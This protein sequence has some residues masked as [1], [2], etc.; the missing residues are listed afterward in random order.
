MTGQQRSIMPKSLTQ[1]RHVFLDMDG[2]IYNGTKLFPTTPGFLA[3]L[4]A[5]GRG[6]TFLTNNSSRST[7]E[8]VAKLA[9]MGLPSEPE[10][11]Y[12]STDYAIDYLKTNHPEFSRLYLLGVPAI[13]PAF[14]AAGFQLVEEAPDA[15]IVAFDKTLTY[16]TLCRAAWFIREG[17][18]AF[19]THPDVFCPAEPG[20]WLVDCG[21][22]TACLESSTGK[23]ITVLGKPDP[24]FLRAAAARKGVPVEDVLMCGDRVSTDIALGFYAGSITCR[25]LSPDSEFTS[26]EGVVP[27]YTVNHL[28][29]LQAVWEAQEAKKNRNDPSG[30][31]TSSLSGLV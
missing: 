27:D 6:Y 30:R 23:K 19:A 29:E 25:I 15:V 24:G 7:A 3:F 4:T 5:A 8:Y 14:A 9:K 13:R 28:G 22:I 17:I 12:T 1:V 2:T 18:P 26:P 31:R 10:N 16:R 20:E 21:A 11:F